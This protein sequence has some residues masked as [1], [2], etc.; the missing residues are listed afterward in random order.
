MGFKE[1]IGSKKEGSF[2]EIAEELVKND[3]N[4]YPREN[5]K[6]AKERLQ[7]LL[8]SFYRFG[9][10]LA[11]IIVIAGIL[12]FGAPAVAGEKQEKEIEKVTKAGE[13]LK[14]K[15]KEKKGITTPLYYGWRV[16]ILP[17]EIDFKK[18]KLTYNILRIICPIQVEKVVEKDMGSFKFEVPYEY[19][20]FFNIGKPLRP[21]DYEKVKKYVSGEIQRN[22]ENKLRGLN[23]S[24]KTQEEIDKSRE[25][26]KKAEI[27]KITV[28]GSAS[29]EGPA[30]KG[31]S[32]IEPGKV[33]IENIK[34]ARLRAENALGITRKSLEKLGIPKEK[35]DKILT[36]I[37]AEELQFTPE[38]MKELILLSKDW[39]GA[40]PI[41]K[42]FNM[43][44]DYNDEKIQDPKLVEKLH[45]IVASKRKVEIEIELKG[46]EK[47]IYT[48]PVPL[49]LGLLPFLRFG[50][51]ERL[52]IGGG[53]RRRKIPSYEEFQKTQQP[54]FKEKITVEPL[55]VNPQ[56]DKEFPHKVEQAL[57]NDIYIFFDDE[58]TKE[59]GL[60][61]RTLCDKMIQDFDNF[62]SDTDRKNYLA[63]E[64]L[65]L[66]REHDIKARKEAGWSE[67][68]IAEGLDYENQ[69]NQILWSLAHAEVLLKLI[70]EKMKNPNLDYQDIMSKEV[71]KYID[72]KSK[73]GEN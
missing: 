10:K 27:E 61:Y 39:G 4:L 12:N 20:R 2:S 3:P 46:R 34:L 25:E 5:I 58:K 23:L 15:K 72:K 55:S 71:E 45:K 69:P 31:S 60:D 70:K 32:T 33:D 7:N 30:E 29:P 19:A 59:R 35:I 28:L 18:D 49:L 66:W 54:Q 14:L 68:N 64:L 9:L 24:R 37:K 16:K 57:V 8:S 38:E 6:N 44:V 13:V 11:R 1:K 63:R 22:L 67:E 40:N 62:K 42:I 53:R 48:I 52:L 43:I 50:R 65:R 51:G 21:E 47:I 41:E 56:E 26:I 36:E 17:L 73:E